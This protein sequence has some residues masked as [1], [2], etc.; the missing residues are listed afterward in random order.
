MAEKVSYIKATTPFE[1]LVHWV[2]AG[3]C[4]VLI[5]TG[6]DFLFHGLDFFSSFFGDSYRA[7]MQ[8]HN[9]F[10]ILFGL[11]LLLAILVWLRYSNWNMIGPNLSCIGASVSRKRFSRSTS[12]KCGFG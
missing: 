9:W 7:V 3:S 6:I 8:I 1:R 5:F 11:S 4:L 12:R 2:L 10:G